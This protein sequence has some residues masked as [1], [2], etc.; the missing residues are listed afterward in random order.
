MRHRDGAQ[1][2]PASRQAPTGVPFEGVRGEAFL[3][4]VERR[5]LNGRLF[6]GQGEVHGAG[7]VRRRDSSGFGI[8]PSNP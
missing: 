7:S 8:I 4:E 5:F 3:G 2:H 6:L 1:P